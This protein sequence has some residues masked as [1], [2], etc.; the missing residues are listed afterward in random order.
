MTG[1]EISE[2]T[3]YDI[4]FLSYKRCYISKISVVNISVKLSGFIAAA[5]LYRM[6]LEHIRGNKCTM[7]VL[8]V[9]GIAVDLL[10]TQVTGTALAN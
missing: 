1:Y 5:A 3:S 8:G 4:L 6:N 7:T 2:W 10:Y 9:E